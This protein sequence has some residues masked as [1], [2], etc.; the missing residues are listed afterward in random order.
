MWE[1]F[2]RSAGFS[3]VT[4]RASATVKLVSW[5]RMSW[6]SEARGQEAETW[7]QRTNEPGF[8]QTWGKRT[9]EAVYQAAVALELER[10]RLEDNWRLT[11]LMWRLERRRGRAKAWRR[12]HRDSR[13]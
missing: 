10:A 1:Q 12:R 2:L 6:S 7:W 4:S 13:D 9:S 5:D 8:Q 3:A 11:Y